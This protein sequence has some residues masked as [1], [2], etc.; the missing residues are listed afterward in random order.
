MAFAHSGV[1]H[2]RMITFTKL[3][4]AHGISGVT[5]GQHGET[6]KIHDTQQS[7]LQSL[8]TCHFSGSAACREDSVCLKHGNGDIYTSG[9]IT[10]RLHYVF[11]YCE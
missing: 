4:M 10:I 8:Y 5:Q 2:W 7:A 9:G 3:S 6:L 11:N 1:T